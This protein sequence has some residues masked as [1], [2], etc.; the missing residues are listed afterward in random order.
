MV[1]SRKSFKDMTALAYLIASSLALYSA[2][3]VVRRVPRRQQHR[4]G[5]REAHP[6]RQDEEEPGAEAEGDRPK[7]HRQGPCQ[8]DPRGHSGLPAHAPHHPQPRAHGH[9]GRE[10]EGGL[11]GRQP[12]PCARLQQRQQAG[13]AHCLLMSVSLTGVFQESEAAPRALSSTTASASRFCT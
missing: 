2:L 8:V 12:L 7:R 11:R 13:A 1:C 5:N 6:H 3:G 9:A 10:G 4:P